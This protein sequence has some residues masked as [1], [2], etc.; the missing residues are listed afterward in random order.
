MMK[1]VPVGLYRQAWTLSFHVKQGAA[2]TV[3][4]SPQEWHQVSCYD[5]TASIPEPRLSPITQTAEPMGPAT[6]GDLIDLYLN[7]TDFL[8]LRDRTKADYRKQLASARLQFGEMALCR[9]DARSFTRDIFAW[10]DEAR[11]TPRVADYRVQVLKLLLAWARRRGLIDYNRAEK[12]RQLYRSRR[13]L[14]SWS[15]DHIA[16]FETVAPA[17]LKFAL[18]IALETGQRQADLL[19][20]EWSAIENGFIH[21]VQQKTGAE[22]AVPIS[23]VLAGAL[24]RLPG[25]R[26]GRVL[27]RNNGEPWSDGP[28]GFRSAWFRTCKAASIRGVTFHDLRG[29]FVTLRLSQGWTALEV[30]MCTGHSL[31]DLAILDGYADR[32]VV[33]LRT[34]E[35]LA[36]RLVAVKAPAA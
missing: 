28:N 19:S 34:A 10:R 11:S 29:T 13:R 4:T 22:V 24:D 32:K 31:R 20:L 6:L 16:A 25:D 26:T 2:P 35:R 12:M 27:R 14:V 21:V 9:V 1:A 30:A 17:H 18:L 33:A 5:G 7:S 8:G 23:P 36:A 15:A 3:G